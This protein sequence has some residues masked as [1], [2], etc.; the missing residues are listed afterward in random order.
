MEMGSTI[1]RRFF[2]LGFSSGFWPLPELWVELVAVA[3]A[4]CFSAG[5]A[6]YGFSSSSLQV[7]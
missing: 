5:M 1:F 2:G 4:K 3:V 7:S 6:S